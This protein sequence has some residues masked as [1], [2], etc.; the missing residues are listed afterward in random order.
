MKIKILI[1]DDNKEN[2][3]AL[4]HLIESDDV[5]I[6]SAANANDALELLTA[7]EFGL[8]LLD[9]N[10]PGTGGFELAK[11]IRGVKSFRSLPIIYVTAHPEDSSIVFEGYESGAVDILFKPLKANVVRAKV[12][13][14]VELA[15][16]K[17]LLQSH[18][19]ELERLRIEAESANIA[20]SQFLANM[21]H[22][23]RTPLAA[24]M[25]FSELIARNE[26]S[27]SENRELVAAVERNGN[28][29]L[30]LIDDILD[31]SKI[32][33]NRLEL[34]SV[35]FNLDDLLRDVSSTM[36]FRANEKGL[37]LD[38]HS[39]DLVP[40][41]YQSDPVRIKQM[42]LNIIGN[43]IKFTDSGTIE[44][45]V[46]IQTTASES[47]D[48]VRVQ[49]KDQ[50]IGLTA[51]QAERLFR[52]FGQGDASMRRKFGGSG[53]GLVISR[54][55]A[56]FMDGDIRLLNSSP[57][58][59]STFLIE[60]R[61]PRAAG[62]TIEKERVGQHQENQENF[63]EKQILVVD[64]S[65]DNL[66]LIELFLADLGASLTF[67]ESGEAAIEVLKNRRFD[68]IL[69]D[70]QMPGKDGHETTAEIRRLGFRKPIVALTAHAVRSEH[71]KCR[72][73]GCDH[74]LTKPITRRRLLDSIA[75]FL[76]GVRSDFRAKACQSP[77]G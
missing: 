73:S 1:V 76:E 74:V 59:G 37:A 11:I 55:I 14:F 31:L 77:A 63:A 56:R 62:K 51:V 44:V 70:I 41:L 5:E 18:V 30:R 69:M 60:F 54:Q 4:S 35:T 65:Q 71:D 16:Q 47:S 45:R 48:S 43:A 23:I 7:N 28:L 29:L 27:N 57:G 72:L 13:M 53:L 15:R 2:T 52:P 38:F 68:L 8:A 39:P 36:A 66:I 49:V 32:E 26:S 6:F 25:G 67:V 21:S 12:Q 75:P 20:K 42:F 9:V 46:D 3:R 34:E 33:A 10:M 50:G 24:V 58:S 22:E 64:D 61:L 40:S 17:T 19:E